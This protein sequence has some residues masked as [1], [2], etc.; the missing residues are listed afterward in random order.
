[1]V[2][3]VLAVSCTEISDRITIQLQFNV[4]GWHNRRSRLEGEVYG[5]EMDGKR[6]ISMLPSQLDNEMIG[7][8]DHILN[9]RSGKLQSKR[10]AIENNEMSTKP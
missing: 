3:G 4:R 8:Y 2:T 9:T 7:I 1:M 6:L 10:E 5:D